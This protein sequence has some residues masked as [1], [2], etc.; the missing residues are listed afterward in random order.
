[1]DA[2]RPEEKFNFGKAKVLVI[3]SSV[4]SQEVASNI[5]QAFGFRAIFRS[6]DLAAAA[7][8]LAANKIDLMLLDPYT[9]GSDGYEFV[10]KLRA[11]TQSQNT[12]TPVI[13]MTGYTPVR[14][15]TEAQSCG[16]DFI[17]AKPFSTAS[18]LQRIVF[19]ASKAGH[20]S[21]LATQQTVSKDGSGMELW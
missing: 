5:L 20:R 11:N 13:M 12:L 9:F 6:C 10:R 15:V 3:D 1:M 4:I 2:L 14:S 8:I 16:A 19:V 17:V 21:E 7:N 18:L